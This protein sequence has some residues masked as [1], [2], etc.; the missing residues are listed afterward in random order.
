MGFMQDDHGPAR[1]SSLSNMRLTVVGKDHLHI[2]DRASCEQVYIHNIPIDGVP[3]VRRER[4]PKFGHKII[5]LA[6]RNTGSRV[7]HFRIRQSRRCLFGRNIFRVFREAPSTVSEVKIFDLRENDRG[8]DHQ[9]ER[10]SLALGV[11]EEDMRVVEPL[12][13]FREYKHLSP[14]IS[15]YAFGSEN[16]VRFIPLGRIGLL[17]MGEVV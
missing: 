10:I 17:A 9:N 2:G 13:L 8:L 16:S 6:E 11:G 4:V 5:Q 3:Q 15:Q 1:V 12:S 7:H 14:V